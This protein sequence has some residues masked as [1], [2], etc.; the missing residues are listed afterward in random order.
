M[1]ER[2]K[3][4]IEEERIRAMN[5]MKDEM[6]DLVILAASKVIEK[7]IDKDKHKELIDEFI[8]RTG[9]VV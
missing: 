9:D 6:S 2:A 3:R 7:E 8:D 1:K 4:E 5:D